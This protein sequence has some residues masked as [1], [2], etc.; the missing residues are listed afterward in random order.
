MKS[1]RA[2]A[3][4]TWLLAQFGCSPKNESLMGDIIEEYARGRSRVW[5][6]RQV[7]V[8]LAAGLVQE[9][10][11]H[12]R[13]AARALATGWSFVV[14]WWLLAVLYYQVLGRLLPA[15]WWAIRW[16]YVRGWVLPRG[17]DMLIVPVACLAGFGI[18]WIIGRLYR[19]HHRAMV[20]L[21][22]S[23]LFLALVPTFFFVLETMVHGWAPVAWRYNNPFILLF[24]TAA[25]IVAMI[26]ILLG[27]CVSQDRPLVRFRL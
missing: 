15:S 10:R 27:G 4:A 18:G 5:Y 16:I 22:V 8:A 7:L 14:L 19:P 25:N 17:V 9:V 3:L 13:I 23:S 1:S 2:P 12:W 20:L 21:F 11:E 26:C 6:W 24:Y